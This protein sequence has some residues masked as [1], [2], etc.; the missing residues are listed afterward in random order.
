M[1][2][3]TPTAYT[4]GILRQAEHVGMTPTWQPARQGITRVSLS[5]PGPHN[6][7]GTIQI[8]ARSGRVLRAELIY[9]N[10]RRKRTFANATALRQYLNGHAN[11]RN[12]CQPDCAGDCRA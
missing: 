1:S 7:F 12:R 9:Q 2:E 5:A 8:G 4:K 3:T 10:G 11:V 6:V